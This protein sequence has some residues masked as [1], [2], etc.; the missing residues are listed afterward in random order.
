MKKA[1]WMILLAL[2]V[3][4]CA[5]ACQIFLRYQPQPWTSEAEKINRCHGE[6]ECERGGEAR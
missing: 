6:P 4:A 5:G 1:C 3:L 2:V